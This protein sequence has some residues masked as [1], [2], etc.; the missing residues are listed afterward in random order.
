MGGRCGRPGRCREVRA[1]AFKEELDRERVPGVAQYVGQF[2]LT[3]MVGG[4]LTASLGARLLGPYVPIGEPDVETRPYVV[5][6]LG[7]LVPLTSTMMADVSLQNLFDREYP[8]LRSSGYVNPETRTLRVSSPGRHERH[9]PN[10][11]LESRMHRRAARS[12][13]APTAPPLVLACD[14]AGGDGRG[15][16]RR[17]ALNDRQRRRD[18]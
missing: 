1:S 10:P 14:S 12:P 6:D 3:T 2:G 18:G 8:E 17:F 15:R 16:P 11:A 13:H 9:L 4:R 7:A 5:A